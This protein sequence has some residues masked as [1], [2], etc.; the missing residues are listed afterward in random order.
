M[1]GR[2]SMAEAEQ[3]LEG[4]ILRPGGTYEVGMYVVEYGW[5][6]GRTYDISVVTTRKPFRCP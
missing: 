5:G 4:L 3:T 2:P 1:L 6:I